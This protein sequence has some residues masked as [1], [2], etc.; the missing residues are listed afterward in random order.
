[1]AL[2]LNATEISFGVGLCC[3]SRAHY[4]RMFSHKQNQRLF[5]R[6]AGLQCPPSLRLPGGLSAWGALQSSIR[7]NSRLQPVQA[8]RPLGFI[9]PWRSRSMMVWYLVAPQCWQA[10]TGR[11]GA[12]RSSS[13]KGE[14]ELGNA[15][16]KNG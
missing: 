6:A 2:P 12:P 1:M 16:S 5:C 7:V 13:P 11:T 4:L 14:S 10:L 15:C 9:S 8:Q 3:L